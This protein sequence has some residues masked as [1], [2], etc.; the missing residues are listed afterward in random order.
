MSILCV[1]FGSV[2]TRALLLDVVDGVYQLIAR[3]ET[4]TTDGFPVNDV[5]VGLDRVLR[6]LNESTGRVL[7]N[8]AGTLI[9]PEQANRTG[10][11]LF[12][13][14]TS[15]GRPLRLLIV[16]LTADVSTESA[17]K[18][19]RGTYIDVVDV[20]N[21]NDQRDE[22][23]RINTVI[24]SQPDTILIVGGTERGAELPILNLAENIRQAVSLMEANRRPSIIYAGNSSLQ[25]N[26]QTLFDGL[27][28][29]FIAENIRP[30]LREEQLYGA[31]EKL[32]EA[33]DLHQEKNNAAFS[34]IAEMSE[35]GVRPTLQSYTP[36]VEYLHKTNRHNVAAVD[37]GSSSSVLT[38]AMD[39]RVTTTIR[40]NTGVGQSAQALLAALDDEVLQQLPF[41]ITRAELENYAANK[42]LRPAYVPTTQRDLYIEHALLRGAVRL[43]A[44]DAQHQRWTASQRQIG[45]LIAAGAAFSSTGSPGYSALLILDALQPLGIT[46]LYSDPYA[47]AAALGGLASTQPEAVVQTLES[48]NLEYLGTSFSLSGAPRLDARALSVT[49]AVEGSTTETFDVP[50]GHLR[51]FPLPLGQRAT[52]QVR[53]LGRGLSI[54]GR[55][56]M[57][58]TVQ[59][60][61]AGVIFDARGRSL[62]PLR[63]L[64]PARSLDLQQR[65]LWMPRWVSEVTG[66]PV[67]EIDP[68]WLVPP[69]T[70]APVAS[71]S[72][73]SGNSRGGRRFGRKQQP[74][75]PL[76]D[77]PDDLSSSSDDPEDELRAL[78]DATLS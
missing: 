47:L 74:G 12:S 52:V 35:D 40:A 53:V 60:G 41:Y 36:I 59:G 61:T 3:A 65:A 37:V 42:M 78:R 73:K 50:G 62:D 34:T 51:L 55:A 56:R 10:V 70:P 14:T 6:E 24:L 9:V 31:R 22:Q 8:P 26:I 49:I 77:L 46:Q 19:I 67:R 63:S 33:F 4:R 68:A 43:L 75:A 45:T 44:R 48:G 13:A 57:K 16:G 2:Y 30:S 7:T 15:M 64:Q 18:S 58:Q 28:K 29:V 38:T 72:A 69:A 54:G 1:D 76:P 5:T 39:D 25:D 21:L 17:L 66:D 11:D 20:L 71:A 32:V 27:S 23:H